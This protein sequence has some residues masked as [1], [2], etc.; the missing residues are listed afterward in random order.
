[1]NA[2]GMMAATGLIISILSI[3][4]PTYVTI[5][6]SK[7]KSLS[8]TEKSRQAFF[9]NSVNTPTDLSLQLNGRPVKTPWV[10]TL[11]YE[12]TGKIPVLKNDVESPVKVNF[13]NSN[14]VDAQ[15]IGKSPGNISATIGKST[16][17]IQIT[18]GLL[19][20]GDKIQ[21]S[22]L[23][24]GIGETP[25]IDGRVSD[26]PAV[27]Y[28]K[29]APEARSQ[30]W[31]P[32]SIT[33]TAQ[34]ISALL[35]VLTTIGLTA[36]F[37][38][39][40]KTK[41]ERF[42]GR[43]FNKISLIP[44]V[45]IKNSITE[46]INTSNMSPLSLIL[47]NYT[48]D[49][50]SIDWLDNSAHFMQMLNRIDFPEEVKNLEALADAKL[51]LY[52][53]LVSSLKTYAAQNAYLALPVGPDETARDNIMSVDITQF[54]A[55]DFINAVDKH[56]EEMIKNHY[57]N[58]PEPLITRQELFLFTLTLIAFASFFVV[59]ADSYLKS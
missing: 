3:V 54:G 55:V 16:K 45:D 17:S 42:G 9:N 49:H 51:E 57:A 23:L 36:E 43:V 15:I 28:T 22:I 26:I 56:T 37:A 29:Y 38:K 31:I 48:R 53:S 18:H 6:Q 58:H 24:D 14:V 25:V 39:K 20:P 40:I 8:I 35:L 52:Q 46:R 59:I 21:I 2:K 19:N 27:L 12:N 32:K 4:V 41:K 50:L 1:M 33:K 44:L 10:L 13:R 5:E 11:S 34:I 30:D 47:L 7:E